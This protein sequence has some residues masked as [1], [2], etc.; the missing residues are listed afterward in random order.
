MLAPADMRFSQAARLLMGNSLDR[1][2]A[3][4]DAVNGLTGFTWGGGGSG[5]PRWM[6]KSENVM[7]SWANKDRGF[8]FLISCGRIIPERGIKS[9]KGR[10]VLFDDGESREFDIIVAATGFRPS[11]TIM[12]MCSCEVYKASP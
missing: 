4:S 12:D 9:V 2:V 3:V 7:Q 6:P 11:R 8:K 5:V 1:F 10:T